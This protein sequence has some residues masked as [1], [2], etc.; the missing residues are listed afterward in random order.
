MGIGIG[1]LKKVWKRETEEKN[2]K[3][4]YAGVILE[5]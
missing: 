4:V 1:C 3:K 5:R 2:S